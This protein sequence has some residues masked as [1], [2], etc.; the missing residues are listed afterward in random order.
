MMQKIL[1]RFM[2]YIYSLLEDVWVDLL[3]AG[4]RIKPDYPAPPQLCLSDFI[5]LP[6]DRTN[7][8]GAMQRSRKVWP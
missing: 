3:N 7:L 5:R 4:H 6:H 1:R 8:F 2:A